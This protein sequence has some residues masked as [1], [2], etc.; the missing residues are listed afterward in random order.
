MSKQVGHKCSRLAHTDLKTHGLH[1]GS[2]ELEKLIAEQGK[3]PEAVGTH[4]HPCAHRNP[5]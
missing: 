3:P 2:S 4:G 5:V 1:H